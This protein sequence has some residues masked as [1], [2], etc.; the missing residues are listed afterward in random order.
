MKKVLIV[1]DTPGG[2]AVLREMLSRPFITLLEA[3]S[4]RQALEIHRRE[5]VD[6]IVLDLRMPGMDGDWVARTIRADA[7]MRH[8]SILMFADNGREATRER[9]LSAGANDFVSKP[10]QTAELMARVGHLLDIA[11]RKKIGRAHV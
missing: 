7:A 2:L 6:L 4:G 9:C 3:S 8:V 10:F 5:N 11:P 1:D